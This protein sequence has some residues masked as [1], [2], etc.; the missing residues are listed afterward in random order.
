MNRLFSINPLTVAIAVVAALIGL[1]FLV[2]DQGGDMIGDLRLIFIALP[3]AII[4]YKGFDDFV[5][6]TRKT[7]EWH[8][9]WWLLSLPFLSVIALNL[10][11][12][13][14]SNLQLNF[15]EIPPM[16]FDNLMVGWIEEIWLRGI[17]FY[18]CY[19]AWGATRVGLIAACI[20]QALAFGALHFMNIGVEPIAL[21]GFQVFY[22]TAIGF[23][24]GALMLMTRSI[25]PSILIH[26][27]IDLVSAVEETFNPD[28]VPATEFTGIQMLIVT[29]ILFA[30]FVV[31]G[32]IYLFK[33]PM[34]SGGTEPQ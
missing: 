13:S 3:I 24:F 7:A 10:T 28:Y 16:L 32:L 6:I 34:R 21:V 17:L 27:G 23:G 5:G 25:W 2:S 18:I 26:A 11:S 15:G 20:V 19:K 29:V 12:V 9:R 4:L 1:S 8:P 14:F 22:A 30:T 33:V 31:P